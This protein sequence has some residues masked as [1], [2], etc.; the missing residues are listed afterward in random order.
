MATR[1]L[2]YH[3]D[4][5]PIDFRLDVSGDRYLA[6]LAFMFARQRYACADSMIGAS[7]GG[8]VVGSIARSLLVDGLRWLWIGER[9]ERRRAL[10]GDLLEERNRIC[11]VLADT[12]CS[13]PILPRWLMPLPDI[14]DLTGASMTWLDAP[15]MPTEDEL[16]HEFLAR[17]VPGLSLA[18]TGDGH[19]GLL[20]RAGSLLDMAGLR[21]AVMVL[22]HAG[23]GNYLGLQSCLSDDG[24]PGHDLRTDHEALFMQAAAIGTT[25]TL[26]GSS[27]AV[28]EW[29]P[30]EVPQQQFL[31]RAVDLTADVSSAAVVMHPLGTARRATAAA[32][33]R[34]ARDRG[35]LRDD[36]LLAAEDLLPDANS[37]DAVIAA[38]EEYYQSARVQARTISP[39]ASGNAVLHALLGYAGAHSNLQAVMSTYDQ[40]GSAVIAV[41][42]ARMLLEEA[43]R[44]YW[45]FSV[46][47][48]EF[49]DRAK[50]YF[51]EFRARRKKT[52]DLL[53]SSGVHENGRG[54]DV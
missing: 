3:L 14:A 40:P 21:G 15:A 47:G 23:H 7:F 48:T 9:P 27:A 5:L 10:L 46:S 28:S 1:A 51:D 32:R 43:A 41:F 36:A 17:A 6:G 54:T 13:C 11:K 42:A 12:E 24:V 39:W 44:M 33:P 19:S 37:A 4:E 16:L 35:L 34:P 20:D 49:E 29:W 18:G 38:A 52:I 22:A 25:L 45:R 26:L 2:R 50:Q 53:V 30:A 31:E 8:T